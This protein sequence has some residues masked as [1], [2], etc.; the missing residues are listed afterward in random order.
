MFYDDAGHIR[1]IMNADE[2]TA[3][4]TYDSDGRVV[5]NN[6]YSCCM[7]TSPE[8][9]SLRKYLKSNPH[10]HTSNVMLYTN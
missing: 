5:S 7:C 3:T 9:T 1:R 8:I 2:T 10:S 6:Y 4:F